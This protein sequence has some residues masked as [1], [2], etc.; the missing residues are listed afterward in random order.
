ASANVTHDPY[1]LKQTFFTFFDDFGADGLRVLTPEPSGVRHKRLRGLRS[2][3]LGL[4]KSTC[5]AL[6]KGMSG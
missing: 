3:G 4:N 5:T 1:Y 2:S 6:P